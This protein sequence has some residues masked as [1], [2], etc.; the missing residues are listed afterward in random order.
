MPEEKYPIETRN[1]VGELHSFN[2]KPA[3]ITKDGYKYWYK[4]GRRHRDNDLPAVVDNKNNDYKACGYKEWWI[5]GIRHRGFDRP[6]FIFYD[7]K[8]WIV[9][10]KR[11]REN[12][13]PALI[14]P[15]K[16]SWFKNNKLSR[17]AGKPVIVNMSEKRAS[18]I[19]GKIL[20]SVSYEMPEEER[21]K[22]FTIETEAL[23]CDLLEKPYKF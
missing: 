10:G 20:K 18:F 11:H 14:E 8:I 3:I 6:A 19:N 15:G 7:V 12:D 4:N 23:I 22:I 1:E 9:N 13:L 17:E 5:D 2:D 21:D 16:L